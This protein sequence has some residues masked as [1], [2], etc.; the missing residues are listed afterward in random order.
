MAATKDHGC[1]VD[2]DVEVMA[3]LAFEDDRAAGTDLDGLRE[4]G[5]ENEVGPVEGGEQRLAGHHVGDPMVDCLATHAHGVEVSVLAESTL[6]GRF[7]YVPWN[8]RLSRTVIPRSGAKQYSVSALPWM[9]PVNSE[10]ETI[11]KQAHA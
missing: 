7:W 9:D 3:D 6:N 10:R 1:A 8:E 4:A 2:D 5:Q 11:T